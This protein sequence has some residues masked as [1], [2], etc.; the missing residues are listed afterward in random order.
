MAGSGRAIAASLR[1]ARLSQR[2][3]AAVTKSILV[4]DDHRGFAGMIARLL[5][6]AGYQVALAYDGQEALDLVEGASP[7]LVLSDVTM[8]RMDGPSLARTLR[9]HGYQ[10]PIL[11]MSAERAEPIDLDGVV[12]MPKPSGVADLIAAVNDALAGA[13]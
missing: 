12:F 13:S 11:L 3:F 1:Y 10:M 7:D 6:G 8:P 5:R 9:E 2:R 4:V